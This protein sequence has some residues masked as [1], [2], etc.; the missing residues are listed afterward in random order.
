METKM[1]TA[2]TKLEKLLREGNYLKALS[3]ASKFPRLGEHKEQ[4]RLGHEANQNPSF[5]RQI[6]KN[7]DQLVADGIAALKDR[8]AYLTN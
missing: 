1:I 2:S 5:Y 6:G 7:P 3:L 4:I 8:Y